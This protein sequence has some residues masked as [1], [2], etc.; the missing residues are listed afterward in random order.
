MLATSFAIAF[1]GCCARPNTPTRICPPYVSQPAALQVSEKPKSAG[2]TA[3]FG[4]VA[5]YP[6]V[7]SPTIATAESAALRIDLLETICLAASNS[8]QADLIEAERH[9]LRCQSC[10]R[11]RPIIDLILQGEALEQRN[12][13]AGLAAEL[14]L[15]LAQVQLQRELVEE[16]TRHLNNLEMTIEAA[17]DA[18]LAT[19]DG[20]NELAKG[21]IRINQS[22]SDLNAAEQK[23][24]YQ[25]NRLI[26]PDQANSVSFTPVHELNLFNPNIVSSEQTEIA[27]TSRPGIRALEI[28]VTS[29]PNSEAIYKMLGQFDSILGIRIPNRPGVKRLLRRQLMETL[30]KDEAPDA[31]LQTR[32]QQVWKIIEVRTQE[33]KSQT[34]DAVAQLQHALEKLAIA[35]EDVARLDARQALLKSKL[36]IDGQGSYLELN[37]NFIDL[38]IAK[39]DRISAA[40]EFETAK[41]KLLQAQGH[42][43]LKCGYDLPLDAVSTTE[44]RCQ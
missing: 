36:E 28:A 14:F 24:Q 29:Q 20:K 15:G 32:R 2:V 33:A 42:L 3:D 21:R 17:R 11:S 44:C 39:K 16:S 10:D 1:N 35:N 12:K 18:G 37:R 34:S 19:A 25:L 5:S 9:A 31:T 22:N 26:N 30:A 23:L 38:Q 8:S 13:S 6:E 4:G 27:A 40:I 43:I 7:A 41:I